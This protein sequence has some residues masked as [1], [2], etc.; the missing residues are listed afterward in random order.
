MARAAGEEAHPWRSSR[1]SP[2]SRTAA[3]ATP[4]PY[5]CCRRSASTPGP[6]PPR[7]V[8]SNPRYP[9]RRDAGWRAGQAR[10]LVDG[11]E[12]AGVASRA[13][14]V[15]SGLLGNPAPGDALLDAVG[16]A[17]AARV[18]ARAGPARVLVSGVGTPGTPTGCI[19]CIL[20]A[21]SGTHVLRTPRLERGAAGAGDVLA[22][23]F[24]ARRLQGW[25]PLDGARRWPRSC[26]C[27]S[28][29]RRRA[30]RSCRSP[31]PRPPW[32]ARIRGASRWTPPEHRRRRRPPAARRGSGSSMRA[33]RSQGA[34]GRPAAR[35]VGGMIGSVGRTPRR[36]SRIAGAGGTP[37]T[38]PRFDTPLP[39][40]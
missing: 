32:P 15:L 37:E 10:A 30:A 17:R 7:S 20:H 28:G 4:P 23:G 36:R 31:A 22:A 1:S 38:R 6:C 25:M 8:S 29:A 39:P 33:P 26:R 40:H 34:S 27:S 19:E 21:E 35:C 11:L 3:R 5:P 14:G 9:G 2:T 24:F 13:D 16:G 12:A 18:P